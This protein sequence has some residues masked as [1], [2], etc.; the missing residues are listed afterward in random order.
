[1]MDDRST[2]PTGSDPGEDPAE[3][4]PPLGSWPRT[5]LVTL[6]WAA[7]VIALLRWMTTTYNQPLG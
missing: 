6:V 2:Q 4:R 5:Y 3:G 7:L 1:M